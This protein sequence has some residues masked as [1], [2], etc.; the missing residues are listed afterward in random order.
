MKKT[1]VL[2]ICVICIVLSSIITFALTDTVN[3]K[4]GDKVVISKEEYEK[5]KNV[6]DEFAKEIQLRDYIRDKFYFEYDEDKFHEYMNKA[7][8]ESL[9]DPYSYYMTE[10]EYKEFEMSSD[11]EYTGVG[12]V[13]AIDDKDR[14]VIVTP[15]EDTPAKKAGI[16]S[17]DII[18]SVDGELASK[19][20]FEYIANKVRGKAGTKVVLELLRKG[21]DKPFKQELTRKLVKLKAVKSKM[22]D[23]KIGYIQIIKFDKDV[24]TEFSKNLSELEQKNIEGL[25][26][27]LR[28][29]PGGSVSEVTKIADE[30]LGKQLIYYAEDKKGNREEEYSDSFKLEIPYVLLVNGG[31]ASASEILAGAVKDTNS[32]EIIGEQT[33]GKGI[34]QVLKPLKSG[35]AFKLTISGYCTPNGTSIHGVGITPTIVVPANEVEKEQMTDKDDNQLQKAIEVVK[36]K[37]MESKE[38]K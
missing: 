21:E 29:N 8:F 25:V 5:L 20:N 23:D 17:G 3:V 12:I 18:V 28:G 30:I 16:K 1:K 2:L 14:I 7:L 6:S 37:I 31:S 38:N 13:M 9:D 32:A 15:I 35:D 27:D 22:L 10:E 34:I 36:E 4:S 19:S 26:I 11:G 33:F 24:A